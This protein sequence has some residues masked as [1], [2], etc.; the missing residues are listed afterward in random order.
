LSPFC[1]EHI[2][3]DP[4]AETSVTDVYRRYCDHQ[5]SIGEPAFT[6]GQFFPRMKRRYKVLHREHG[7]VYLHIRLKELKADRQGS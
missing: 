4:R 5:E 1:L 6:T 3:P 2:V 7:N